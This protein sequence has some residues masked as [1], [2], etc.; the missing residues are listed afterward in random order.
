[1]NT[2]TA[3]DRYTAPIAPFHGRRDLPCHKVDPDI[4]TVP[5]KDTATAKRFCGHCDIKV[6]CATWATAHIPADDRAIYG[7]LTAHER[8]VARGEVPDEPTEPVPPTRHAQPFSWKA[9]RHTDPRPAFNAAADW[10]RNPRRAREH[11]ARKHG[12]SVT[13]LSDAVTVTRHTPHIVIDVRR[14]HIAIG[15]AIRYAREVRKWREHCERQHDEEA[16]A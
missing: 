3:H 2:V 14:G 12:I 10:L 7:G 15:D 16:A 5:E 6:E 1:M 13:T 8:A 4:F 9:T 11:V